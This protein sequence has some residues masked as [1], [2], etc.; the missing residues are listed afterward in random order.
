M[1]FFTIR[2]SISLE[3]MFVVETE[4]AMQM[5]YKLYEKKLLSLGNAWYPVFHHS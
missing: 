3:G 2:R 5:Y 4:M 1:F